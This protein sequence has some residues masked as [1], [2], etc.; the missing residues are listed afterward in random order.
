[1]EAGHPRRIVGTSRK[2]VAEREEGDGIEVVVVAVVG[3]VAGH[4]SIESL[5][6]APVLQSLQ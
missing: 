3:V 6:G 1:M 2:D 4:L 5:L